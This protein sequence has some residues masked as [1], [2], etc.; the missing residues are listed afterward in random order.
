MEQIVQVLAWNDCAVH[1]QLSSSGVCETQ[2]CGYTHSPRGHESLLYAGLGDGTWTTYLEGTCM[3]A[4]N[5]L[6]TASQRL[7]LLE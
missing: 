5:K 6:P 1:R 2:G 4:V 7:Q 3:V